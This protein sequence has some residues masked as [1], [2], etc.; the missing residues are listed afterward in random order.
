MT[1][2]V[3]L[4]ATHNVRFDLVELDL[5]AAFAGRRLPFP[6]RVPSFGR[7]ESERAD[8]F[9]GAAASLTRRGLATPHGPIGV[10]ADLVRFIRAHRGAVDL[11]VVADRAVTGVVAMVLGADAILC[12]QSIGGVPG[13]VTV[14]RVTASELTDELATAIPRL[15]PAPS[16]PM[17]LPPGVVEEV[18]I[19]AADI[20]ASEKRVR[21]LTRQ[22]GGDE[23]A[24]AELAE[25]L[26]S[27]TGRGQ[28]GA[29]MENRNGAVERPVELSWLDSP[30]GRVRVDHDDRDWLS[31]NPLRHSEMVSAL[32][33][34]ATLARG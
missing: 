6:L 24:V 2:T 28:I 13:T 33:E 29:T 9:A 25:L 3:D 34:A 22:R 19:A 31:V 7:I 10:A 12:R 15:R 16:M 11:V 30:Q 17:T 4:P 5:L 18:E 26:T 20:G 32:R 27:V 23:A 1:T 14:T 8:Y 21:A